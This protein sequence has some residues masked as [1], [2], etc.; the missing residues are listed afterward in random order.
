MPV[1][2]S[3]GN[4]QDAENVELPICPRCSAANKPGASPT[5]EPVPGTKSLFCN[6]CGTTWLP[7]KP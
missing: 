6:C 5:I 3:R 2:G 7:L 4:W 1:D